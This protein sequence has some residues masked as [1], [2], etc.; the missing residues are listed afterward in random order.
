MSMSPARRNDLL[1]AAIGAAVVLLDQLTKNWIVQYFTASEPKPPIP[2][3]SDV[4][5]LIYVPNTGVAFSL[6]EGQT[7]KFIFI[8][9]ALCVICVLYWRSRDVGSLLL[10]LTFGLILGGAIGN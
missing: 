10:K 5:E 7:I 6:F 2:I 4:V 9:I 3:F 8:A 1:M